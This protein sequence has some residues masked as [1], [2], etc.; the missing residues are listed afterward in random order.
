MLVYLALHSIWEPPDKIQIWIYIHG[1]ILI[2]PRRALLLH[3]LCTVCRAHRCRMWPTE[4]GDVR[5]NLA[6][7]E[8][9]HVCPALPPICWAAI[10]RGDKTEMPSLLY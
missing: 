1:P 6:V 10:S 4:I 2:A 3:V 8:N 5:G 9:L 7:V